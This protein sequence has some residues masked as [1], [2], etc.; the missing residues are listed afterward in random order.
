MAAE[1]ARKAAAASKRG[2]FGSATD[3][4]AA[5]S[6]G[7][8]GGAEGPVAAVVAAA[9]GG[10]A[11]AVGAT[12]LGPGCCKVDC[13]VAKEVAAAAVRPSPVSAGYCCQ[14]SAVGWLQ[15]TMVGHLVHGALISNKLK[16]QGKKQVI[17][18][19]RE[20]GGASGSSDSHKLVTPLG[21]LEDGFA[22]P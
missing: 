12:R 6:S 4:F 21:G 2:A 20:V 15:G 3:R 19:D 9:G 5:Q 1:A 7:G 16:Q 22:S 14:Q 11:A 13:G 17:I 18:T 8:G 10:G